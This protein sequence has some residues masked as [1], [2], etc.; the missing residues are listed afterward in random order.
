MVHPQKPFVPFIFFM[1][2]LDNII[3]Q[4]IPFGSK[5]SIANTNQQS[6]PRTQLLQHG[7]L[8]GTNSEQDPWEKHHDFQYFSKGLFFFLVPAIWGELAPIAIM[9]YPSLSRSVEKDKVSTYP[10][11]YMDP[12]PQSPFVKF[13]EKEVQKLENMEVNEKLKEIILDGKGLDTL[14]YFSST[15]F[16]DSDATFEVNGVHLLSVWKVVTIHLQ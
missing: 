16:G 6:P 12:R 4:L 13:D 10:V 7:R 15:P 11:M 14:D 2:E 3:S 5:P 8:H 1:L 9:E